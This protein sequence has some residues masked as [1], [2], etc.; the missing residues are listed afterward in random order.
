MKKQ[1]VIYM[2]MGGYTHVRKHYGADTLAVVRAVNDIVR[3]YIAEHFPNVRGLYTTCIVLEDNGYM[4]RKLTNLFRGCPEFYPLRE[5]RIS[6][7]DGI[8]L[9]PAAL[10]GLQRMASG[11]P[12]Q[13]PAN[14]AFDPMEI[15]RETVLAATREYEEIEAT[16]FGPAAVEY[17]KSATEFLEREH[18]L[19]KWRFAPFM[20]YV[21]RQFIGAECVY[22]GQL[23]TNLIPGCPTF[24]P[25]FA[26]PPIVNQWDGY[27]EIELPPNILQK[28]RAVPIGHE[29]AQS[30]IPGIEREYEIPLA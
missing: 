21:V 10:D 25:Q 5:N 1:E 16:R 29:C 27:R 18:Y 20:P 17:A 23:L 8:V 3:P 11:V 24:Y 26:R 4:G 2:G 9:P 28:V 15:T 14:G 13:A 22:T 12:Y 19:H 6:E 7:I 30:P